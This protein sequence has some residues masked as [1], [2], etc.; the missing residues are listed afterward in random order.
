MAAYRILHLIT[1]YRDGGAETTTRQTLAALQES[2]LTLDLR[3]GYGLNS[4]PN[5]VEALP[6]Y[7]K[8]VAFDL[9]RHYNPVTAVAAVGSVAQYLH[10][11]RID[12]L[13]THSTEA[14]IIGR[15][16]AA[17]ARV[18]IVIHE[19]H[20]DPITEDRGL[21]LNAFLLAAERLCAPITTRFIVKS[22]CIRR[23]FQ[24]RGIGTTEKYTLIRHGVNLIRF[25]DAAPADTTITTDND[26]V[27]LLFVGRLASGKGLFDLL[28]A[29]ERL[30]AGHNVELLLAGD[31]EEQAAVETAIAERDL[32][33][34]VSLLGYRE[35]VPGLMAASDVFVLPSYREG[36]PRVVTEALAAGLPV[37]ATDIAGLP[38]QVTDGET[39]YLI[40]PGNIDALTERLDRLVG[41]PELRA[42]M[43]DRA[44]DSVHAF[45]V[46]I[47]NERFRTLY[48]SLL[49]DHAP[50]S[51]GQ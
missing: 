39:G 22:E 12:V 42:W 38:D 29:M 49:A 11:E 3:L 27:T 13:H 32:D 45:D 15:L 9:I 34:M 19:I 41:D 24:E 14:G 43:G 18:P 7:I 35:D 10:R 25:R 17:V 31:G 37:V 6:E 46:E 5:Q 47:A 16:A 30:V 21:I 51:V 36:T 20:G 26:A 4:D 48:R 50:E 40:E 33:E 2:N 28:S 1:R 8:P 44:A 23:T